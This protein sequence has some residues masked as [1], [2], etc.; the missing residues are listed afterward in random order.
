[1]FQRR[2]TDFRPEGELEEETGEK[3]ESFL[4]S[5]AHHRRKSEGQIGRAQIEV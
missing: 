1:M 2:R 4:K 3:T 5:G